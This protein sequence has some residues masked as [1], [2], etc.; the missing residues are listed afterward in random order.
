M[1]ARRVDRAVELSV[2]ERIPDPTDQEL[3]TLLLTSEE[4][5]DNRELPVIAQS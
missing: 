1:I 2:I 3:V 4:T 5:E